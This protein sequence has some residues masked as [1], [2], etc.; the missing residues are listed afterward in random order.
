MVGRLKQDR[1]QQEDGVRV[2]RVKIVAEH[3][4]FQTPFVW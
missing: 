4:E 3:V 2:Q 1:W